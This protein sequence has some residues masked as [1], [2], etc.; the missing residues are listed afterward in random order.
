MRSLLAALPIL[1]LLG[2]LHPALGLQLG[3]AYP[4]KARFAPSEPVHV[5]AELAGAPLSLANSSPLP[6]RS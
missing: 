1:G 5:V 4:D 2:F 6:L 3:D